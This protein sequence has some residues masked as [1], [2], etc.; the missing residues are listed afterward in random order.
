MKGNDWLAR[1]GIPEKEKN[2]CQE[3]DIKVVYLDT[4]LNSSSALL[5]AWQNFDGVNQ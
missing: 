5:D 1:G 3:L 2:V 4:V